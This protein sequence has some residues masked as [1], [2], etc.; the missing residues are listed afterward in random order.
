MTNDKEVHNF[1]DLD[2]ELCTFC[3]TCV[4]VCPQNSLIAKHGKIYSVGKCKSCGLCYNACPGREVAFSKLNSHIFKSSQRDRYV[5]VYKSL[6]VGH[7]RD[8][9]IRNNASSGGVVTS[10]LIFLLDKGLIDGAIVVCMKYKEPWNYEVKIARTKKDILKASQSKYSLVP[11][12]AILSKI[13]KEDG[14]FALVGL[15]CHIHGIRSLQMMGWEH[16]DKIK[17]LIG[18]FC[19]FNMHL[20]ATNHLINK[21]GVE[22]GDILSLQYRG[23]NYPGGFL[24]KT[25]NNNE[26]SL[27]KFYYNLLNLMYVPKRCLLCVDL[28]NELADI[29]VG[30]AWIK[31]IDK[32]GWSTVIVRT[33]KG[34]T[35]FKDA[36]KHNYLGYK[37][38][39]RE[40]LLKSHSH[41]IR[42][43]KIKVFIRLYLSKK[44]PIYD[45]EYPN[46]KIH[47]YIP[48]AL[49]FYSVKILGN[50][51]IKKVIGFLP[52]KLFGI[53][54][55]L[56]KYIIRKGELE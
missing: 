45:L 1:K 2:P 47:E 54:A 56:G 49:F 40:D 21:L 51:Y 50:D 8:V 30:D 41:L 14:N 23:G 27:E 44:K 42:Y 48:G 4:G 10:L 55:H 24:I 37:K 38:I 17:Y 19:G 32:D 46:M 43:K 11:L 9:K 53:I 25:K 13:R 7:S 20:S 12:N 15:P 39:S 3:G 28:M 31:D 6:Y 5:G 29:S 35:L 52:L 26:K 22:K 36:I 18:L 33:E 16:S 34:E